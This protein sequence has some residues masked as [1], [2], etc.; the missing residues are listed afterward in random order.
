MLSRVADSLYW[1][2]RYL[3]RAEHTA[4]LTDVQI[5]LMLDQS[6][7]ASAQRWARVL[8]S[9]HMLPPGDGMY[10]ARHL[11]DY[12]TFDAANPNSIVSCI[13][14]AREN[15]RQLREHISSEMWEQIN[16]VYLQVKTQRIDDIWETQPHAWFVAVKEGCHLF[17]GITDT[18]MNYNEGYQFLQAGRYL[19][20]A[21]AVAHLLNVHFETFNTE[22]GLGFDFLEWI[23]LLKSCTAFEAYCKVYMADLR[24]DAIAEF[25][26]LNREFPHS[27][28]FS[29][30]R[31]QDA[32]L[33]I[34]EDTQSRRAR[35]VNRLAGRLAALV[36]YGQ[37]DE[38]FAAGFHTFLTEMM[39]QC[40][41][42]HDAIFQAY[43]VYP[44]ERE[45][46]E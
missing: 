12:I 21:T 2:S 18:T 3:E 46:A 28:G 19:E 43:V 40:S 39:R 5:H 22:N 24:P 1:L 45:F 27:I 6:P 29:V 20:R 16:T 26:I 44:V 32:L 38:I 35:G 4:R 33:E 31:V 13:T 34:G 11:T 23:G 41:Q 8:T 14:N 10:D 17:Q 7:A 9:L 25:L 42:I 30:K 36:D 15:A 37:I